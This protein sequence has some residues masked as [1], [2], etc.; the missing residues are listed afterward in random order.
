MFEKYR[1]E[2]GVGRKRVV[3]LAFLTDIHLTDQGPGQEFWKLLD[4]CRPEGVLLGGDL[5]VAK[6]GVQV[7]GAE[8]FVGKLTEK[9]PVWY[10]NGNHERRLLE[11]TE[12]LGE[13]PENGISVP[14]AGRRLCGW[15]TRRQRWRS[16]AAPITIYGLGSAGGVLQ[17]GFPQERHGGTA[18]GNFRRAGE[19]TFHDSSGPY[20]PLL[21]GI[22][23]LGRQSDP[24][25]AT[26]T[27]ASAS[28]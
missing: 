22:S 10:A 4:K 13:K 1:L 26:I 16:E 2:T 19:R 25:P 9:Y 8:K 17:K 3:R 18:S 6:E 7:R 15:L 21:E 14:S 24:C 23:G 28:G 12:T 11:E 20:A 5:M 27:E